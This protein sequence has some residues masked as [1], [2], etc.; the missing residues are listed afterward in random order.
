V[1]VEDSFRFFCKPAYRFFCIAFVQIPEDVAANDQVRG[2]SGKF[3]QR[4]VPMAVELTRLDA[5]VEG[6]DL[7]A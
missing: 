6:L 7:A 1:D 5:R 4:H 2:F 3:L